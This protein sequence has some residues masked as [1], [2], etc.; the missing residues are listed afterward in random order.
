MGKL[1]FTTTQVNAFLGT[2]NDSGME[3][4]AGDLIFNDHMVTADGGLAIKRLNKTGAA[5]VKGTLV[6]ASN[7]TDNAV[8]VLGDEFDC[9]GIVYE[10]GV[11]DGSEM[12]VVI[13]GVVE[14]LLEDSTASVPE[15]WVKASADD[16]RALATTNP[17]S[18]WEL[19]DG[20]HFKEIGH[21]LETKSAGT[22]VL[23][24]I[25]LHFN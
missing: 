10:S 14:V 9:V 13:S 24:K 21:C 22:D 12:W 8:M 16:G 23:C 7:V 1:N 5:S 25:I 19:I 15:N 3:V 4:V 18:I 6:S 17:S 20:E 2:V 11:A